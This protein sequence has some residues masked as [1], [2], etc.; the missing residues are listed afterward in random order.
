M[1]PKALIPLVV[2][3]AIA[4]FAAKMGFDNLRSTE[5]KPIT[6]VSLWQVKQDVPRGAP[7]TEENLTQLDFPA[8][9][10]PQQAVL[11][12]EDILGRVPHT[13]VPAGVPV[14]DSMLLPKGKMPGINV[15]DG[16]RAVAVKINES[17]G[18]DSHL[19]PGVFVDVIGLFTVRTGKRN[20]VIAKTVVEKVEVAA[21][22][23]R[24]APTNPNAVAGDDKGRPAK[25]ARAVTLLVR[26]EHV[27]QLHLAEQRG[28][29]KL[30]MRGVG[31]AAFVDGAE[32]FIHY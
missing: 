19:E 9:F 15:P 17:S 25:P 8:E 3:L 18:V 10:A 22:G 27:P 28:K 4:G 32:C 12:K 26:P 13:G 21:V 31:G 14:L 24:I 7:V 5:A 23:Q 20:A 11:K 29:I 6:M 1:N 16:F 30:S 2:G